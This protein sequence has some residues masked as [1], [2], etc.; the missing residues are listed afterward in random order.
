LQPSVQPVD[1]KHYIKCSLMG[2]KYPL[3]FSGKIGRYVLQHILQVQIF[4]LQ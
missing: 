3:Y 1:K 2:K 4:F